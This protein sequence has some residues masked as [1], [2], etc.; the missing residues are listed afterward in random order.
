LKLNEFQSKQLF[1]RWGVPIP[2]GE[3]AT[4]CEEVSRI[5]VGLGVPVI[6]K[7]QILAG[8]RGK[9]G[10]V[11]PASNPD[12]AGQVADQIFGKRIKGLMVN[13]VLVEEAV[14]IAAELYLGIVIDRAQRRLVIMAS[15]RGGVDIEDIAQSDPECIHRIS[16]D[17]FLGLQDHQG[18]QLAS[19]IGIP[20]D[21]TQDFVKI[22]QGLYQSF[23]A[24]DA[25]LVEINPLV[26]TKEN[27]LLALDG[28][29]LLDDNALFRHPDLSALRENEDEVLQEQEARRHGLNYVKLDGEIGIMVNGAGLAMATMDLI[30]LNGS[31]PANFLDIGGGA[32][33][34]KVATAMRIIL[35]DKNVKSVLLNIF[36]GITRCDEVA[37]GIL[38]VIDELDSDVPL[39]IRLVGTNEEEGRLMLAQA[40]IMTMPTLAEAAQ[41]AIAASQRVA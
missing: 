11:Q 20:K 22:T 16:I 27:K 15:S 14:E 35:M 26:I 38:A 23:I 6:I 7:A 8:G 31:E 21:L 24:N 1:N 36:G 2:R 29:M 12:D 17:P 5:A 9:A 40:G 13:Q 4:N 32:K 30:K 19:G 18:R 37:A 34:E 41:S 39:T 3:I 10:G 28:K 25:Y 33:S